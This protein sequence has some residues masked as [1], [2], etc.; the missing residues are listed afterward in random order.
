MKHLTTMIIVLIA[1]VSFSGT[2]SASSQDITPEQAFELVLKG[3]D[4]LQ[5]L[6]DEA[7]AAFKDPNSEMQSGNSGLSVVDCAKGIVVANRRPKLIGVS[8]EKVKCH[9]TGV[10]FVTELCKTVTPAGAWFEYW[11]L[12]GKDKVLTRRFMFVV[13]V[14]GTPYMVTVGFSAGDRDFEDVKQLTN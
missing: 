8:V 14:E 3:V 2:A 13:P 7:L 9:K 11:Y 5:T 12:V 4:V 10:Q 1:C 6:G